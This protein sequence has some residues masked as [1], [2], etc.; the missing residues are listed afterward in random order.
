MEPSRNPDVVHDLTRLPLPFADNTFQ[1]I[2][3][4]EV[5]EHTGAQGDWRFFFNQWMDFWR[6]LKP[7]GQFFGHSPEWNSDWAW[8]DPGHTRVITQNSFGFLMQTEYTSQIG[9]TC[10]TD[11]RSFYKA[12]FD[13]RHIDHRDGKFFFMLEAVKPSRISFA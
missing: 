1:E 13:V 4:Y 10:M 5:L 6:I 7:G 9:V 12:D 11:Y 2:H 3:A 8:G